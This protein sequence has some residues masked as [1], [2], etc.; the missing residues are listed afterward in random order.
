MTVLNFFGG[1]FGF[2]FRFSEFYHKNSRWRLTDQKQIEIHPRLKPSQGEPNST[3]WKF[4]GGKE[5]LFTGLHQLIINLKFSQSEKG[6]KILFS[7]WLD[8]WKPLKID[9]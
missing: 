3:L 4:T 7:D 8:F 6:T 9:Y 2:F 1:S 5:Q